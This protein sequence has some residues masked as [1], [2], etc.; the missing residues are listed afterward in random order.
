MYM[1]TITI[2]VLHNFIFIF[3]TFLQKCTYIRS[4]FLCYIILL[5]YL[6]RAFR[7][8]YTYIKTFSG[9][10]CVFNYRV[11]INLDLYDNNNFV[12]STFTFEVLETDTQFI[13]L[14]RYQRLTHC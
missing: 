13:L 12:L 4:L 2:F 11:K 10:T 1:H 5:L 6:T 7:N 3:D 8:V 9:C 14:I